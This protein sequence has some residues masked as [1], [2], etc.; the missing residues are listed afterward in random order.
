MGA[1][2]QLARNDLRDQPMVDQWGFLL[3]ALFCQGDD[4]RTQHDES[5]SVIA[6]DVKR[7]GIVCSAEVGGVFADLLPAAQ[8]GDARR[9][10]VRPNLP[11]LLDGRHHLYDG[12]T[13]RYINHYYTQARV[14]NPGADSA[15]PVDHRAELVHEEYAAAIAKLDATFSLHIGDP[16]ARPL[17]R[18]L[19]EHPRVVGLVFGQFGGVSKGVH[20]LLRETANAAAFKHWRQAGA[21]SPQAAVSGYMATYRR[22]WGCIARMAS[23]RLKPA[24]AK[25]AGRG[26]PDP[27]TRQGTS[28]FDPASHADFG[29]A[30][31]PG[32][33]GVARTVVAQPP[34]AVKWFG[35]VF[36]SC[37]RLC[38][39]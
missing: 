15:S 17:T 25:W 18:R 9:D 32:M 21:K 34:V 11:L 3:A 22:R 26:A 36:R 14:V 8:R 5:V 23:A 29:A 4:W 13:L 12:K 27:S 6:A 1:P 30:T 7:A 24:R 2:L 16:S 33:G 37:V 38:G 39:G 31:Y 19:S 35:R 10:G 20:T 28:D